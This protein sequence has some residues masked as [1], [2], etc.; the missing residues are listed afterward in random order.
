MSEKRRW[1]LLSNKSFRMGRGRIIKPNQV[2]EATEEEIPKA[3]R[4]VV[5]PVDPLPQEAPLPVLS[6][7]YQVRS[8]APGWYDVVDSQGKVVNE[9]ALR[10]DAAQ[11]LIEDLS[12]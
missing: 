8:R 4:D 7:G 5:V 1:K 12:K 6:G 10:Q 9:S 3:F 2:F 11:K